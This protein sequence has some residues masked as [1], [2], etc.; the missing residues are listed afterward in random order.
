[1]EIKQPS[2]LNRR[3]TRGKGS[4]TL[5]LRSTTSALEHLLLEINFH[6]VKKIK[7]KLQFVTSLPAE[8]WWWHSFHFLSRVW[9]K[10][11]F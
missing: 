11:L 4:G 5:T 9:G 10:M 7:C 1:M 8:F 3:A 6:E 2:A